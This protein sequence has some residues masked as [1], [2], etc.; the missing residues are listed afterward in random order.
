MRAALPLLLGLAACAADPLRAQEVVRSERAAFQ[1]RDFATGLENPWG[2]AFLPDGRLLVTERPGRLRVVGRDGVVSPP[3]AGVPEVVAQG[4]GGLLDVALSPNFAADRTI[5]ASFSEPRARGRNGTSVFRAR[6]VDDPRAPRLEDLTVIFRQEPSWTNTLHF[7][8]RL[9]FARDGTLFVTVGERSDDETRVQAQDLASG[10]GKVFRINPDGSVPRDNPFVARPGTQPAIW[11][12][13]HRNMQS[14]ALD[15]TGRLWTVEHGPRGGDEL[16]HPEA[17]LNYGWPE[18]TYGIEY[19]GAKVGRGLTQRA[20]T[21]QPVYYWDPVIAPSGMDLYTG[22]QFPDWSNAFL[23]GGLR[24][25]C[26]VVLRMV[27][28][29]VATEE[30]I[31][32]GARVRD[33]KSGPDGAVYILTELDG[34]G[35]RILRMTPKR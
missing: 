16:N 9:V 29:R 21:E 4:Q 18:V 30:R 8:S 34:G 3:L 14:A 6:L 33:V 5:F 24:S 15:G 27:D 32:I 20:G 22:N 26:V 11:S 31:P 7:G 19:R 28:G 12:Y 23:V 1:V 2:A 25:E 10:L 35:S 17:G 13:G